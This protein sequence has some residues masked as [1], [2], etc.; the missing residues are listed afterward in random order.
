VGED[1]F[2]AGYYMNIPPGLNYKKIER[3]GDI[4]DTPITCTPLKE[5][6]KCDI[7]NPLSANKV[8]NFRVIFDPS[9]KAGMAPSYE[10]YMEA[11]STNAENSSASADNVY[12]KNIGIWIETELSIDG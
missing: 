5:S 10:F 11:N 12:R 2:E 9:K 8:V 6:L 4:K 1:A 3:V 7:G